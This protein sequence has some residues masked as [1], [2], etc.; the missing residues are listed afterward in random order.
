MKI[1]LPNNIFSAL[2]QSR[3]QNETIVFR[4]SAL[5]IKDIINDE[6]D[7]GLIPSLDLFSESDLIVSSKVGIAFDANLSNSF[8][9]FKP[10][11]RNIKSLYLR[12]DLSKNDIILSK[13][14]LKEK[15]DFEPEFILDSS[16][17]DFSQKNYLIAGM[18]NFVNIFAQ[19]SISMA[20]QIAEYIEYPYVNFLF[21][22]KSKEILKAIEEALKSVDEKIESDLEKIFESAKMNREIYSFF[23]ENINSLYFNLTDNE[24]NG[25]LEL[26][27]LPYYHGIIDEM[28]EPKF[29]D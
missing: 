26:L 25:L 13:I 7:A 21:V 18:E 3:L 19:N 11:Q 1:S 15:Y 20:D 23:K 12:G 6:T 17:L 16:D 24:I 28:I 14:I 27:K 8:F 22:S 2:I 9:Y 5:I 10:N 4:P 29:T